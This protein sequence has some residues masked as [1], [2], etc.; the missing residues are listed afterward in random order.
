MQMHDSRKGDLLSEIF[1][2]GRCKIFFCNR[3]GDDGVNACLFAEC[4][5]FVHQSCEGCHIVL[6]DLQCRIDK[7]IS[8]IVVARKDSRSKTVKRLTV[9]DKILV[10]INE[11]AL[12]RNVKLEL[13]ALSRQITDPLVLSVAALT[14]STRVLV[15]PLPFL[16]TI[17]LII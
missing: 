7:Q 14:I 9:L 16:P 1:L 2:K 8:D 5:Y 13:V 3:C 12:I 6:A 15:F 11:T 17:N 10:R 4:G